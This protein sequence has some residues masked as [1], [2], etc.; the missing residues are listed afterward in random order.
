[1]SSLEAHLRHVRVAEGAEDGNLVGIFHHHLFILPVIHNNLDPDRE[2]LPQPSEDLCKPTLPQ[3]VGDLKVTQLLVGT[4]VH[5]R[6][7]ALLVELLS[8]ASH[9]GSGR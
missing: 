9:Q 2:T 7:E 4:E 3:E 6:L 1:M 8:Q 5:G